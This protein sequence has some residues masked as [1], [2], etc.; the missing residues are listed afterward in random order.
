MI[1]IL[2]ALTLAQDPD[3]ACLSCHED[4]GEEWRPSVHARERIG[5]VACHG[6]DEVVKDK[7][8]FR[9][10]FRPLRLAQVAEG[11]GACHQGVLEAFRPTE[12]FQTAAF[13]PG[14]DL[15]R[16]SCTACHAH[17][18]TV[19]SDR[20]AILDR[21]ARCHDRTGSEFTAADAGFRKLAALEAATARLL[22]RI[23]G[24]RP[25]AGIPV[26]D[27][28]DGAGRCRSRI[29]ALAVAQHGLGWGAVETAADR[30][31][32]EAEAAYNTL[33]SRER[34]FGGRFRLLVPF[35]ALVAAAAL[36]GRKLGASPP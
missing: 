31:A 30:S 4:Q 21:C 13:G 3:R 33:T 18:A 34:D 6:T 10:T 20:A 1:P 26:S 16:T 19:T 14:D 12:H 29:A 5:C 15:H 22:G 25:R 24:L 32:A 2:L 27:A 11:C 28:E 35:L 36:T 23:D 8:Q 9:P 17:H 7:H